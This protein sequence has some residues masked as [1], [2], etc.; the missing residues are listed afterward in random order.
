[1]SDMSEIP[2]YSGRPME[3]TDL[4]DFEQAIDEVPSGTKVV[5]IEEARLSLITARKL[6]IELRSISDNAADLTEELDII[7]ESYDSNHDHVSEL[8]DYL[9]S[10]IQSWHEVV[11]KLEKSGAKMA[12]LDPGR[13]EWC[14][15]VD[16]KLVM[17]SWSQGEE[18]IEWYHGINSS[19][20]SRKP[21]IEA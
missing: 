5:T 2:I 7:L 15:V 8:A 20:L 10:M 13:L 6:L 3:I 9:A 12:C 17:Y 14:G 11:E 1:M 16:G 21:L 18:D 19:F 4:K